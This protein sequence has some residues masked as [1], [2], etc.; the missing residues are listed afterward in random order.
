MVNNP[1]IIAPKKKQ[2]VTQSRLSMKSDVVGYAH[3]T[4]LDYIQP[5]N[6]NNLLIKVKKTKKIKSSKRPGG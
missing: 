1:F 4:L 6:I 2:L 3:Y 5:V